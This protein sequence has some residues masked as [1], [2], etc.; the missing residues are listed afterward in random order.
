MTKSCTSITWIV[1]VSYTHLDVYKRQG[2]RQ[3]MTLARA[4]LANPPI[5]IL[6]EATASLD[7]KSERQVQEALS[8]VMEGRTSIVIAHRLSTTVSYTHLDVYKRQ[9][10]TNV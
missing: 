3:R 1:A 4:L 7:S 8:R 5:L 2:E 10:L 6:D 9:S